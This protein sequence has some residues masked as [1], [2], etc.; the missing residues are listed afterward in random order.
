MAQSVELLTL[1]F[2]SGRD[3][4]VVRS[5]LVAG[6]VLRV[7]SAGDSPSA[8]PACVRSLSKINKSILFQKRTALRKEL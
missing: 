5:S 6:S 3:L 8:P 1:G 4:R 2:G 7:E